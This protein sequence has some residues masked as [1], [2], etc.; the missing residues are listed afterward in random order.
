MDIAALAE[1]ICVLG[2]RLYARNLVAGKDGNLSCRL[3]DGTFLVTRSGISKGYMTPTD[4]LLADAEGQKLSGEGKVSSEFFTHLAAYA[5]RPEIAAVVH[6][7]PPVATA[8]TLAGVSLEEPYLPEIVM[9]MGR[10]PTCSYA[11]PG[12]REGGEVIREHIRRC[13]TLLLDR[14]GALTVGD[15]LDEAYDKMERLEHAALMIWHARC[16]GPLP[17]LNTGQVAKIHE[18]GRAYGVKGRIWRD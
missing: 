1:R 5:E 6:A 15:S 18:A 14:H 3:E 17:L 7:H 13:D 10:I 9:N 8:L 4:I 12:T 11:T 16:L 2:Q